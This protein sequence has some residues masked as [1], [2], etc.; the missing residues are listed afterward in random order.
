MR[1]RVVHN[2]E[3][4]PDQNQK[5]DKIDTVKINPISFNIKCSIITANLKTPSN[6]V[7]ILVPNTIGT[8]SRENIMSLQIYKKLFPQ[9]KKKMG[10]NKKC[11]YP[12]EIIQQNSNKT[13]GHM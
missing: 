13:T 8:G 11:K 3:Q 4:E 5:E 9:I 10:S 1:G 6:Q 12:G 7:R 2:V